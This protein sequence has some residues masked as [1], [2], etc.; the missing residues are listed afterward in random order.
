[1][2]DPKEQAA[3]MNEEKKDEIMNN[4]QTF[5]DYLGDKVHKG[6]KL[7]LG[8]EGLAKGAKRV[9][10]YLAEHEEPRNRE[11]KVLNELWS[12]ADK[13]EREHIAHALVKMAD[14]TN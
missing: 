3:Q 8:E 4:F 13:N 1:M 12:A 11:E 9:A 7:G 2:K 5:K 10:D 14:Q 6:E